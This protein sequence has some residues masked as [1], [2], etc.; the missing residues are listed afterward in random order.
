MS[1][2]MVFVVPIQ[3]SFPQDSVQRSSAAAES[4]VGMWTPF[5]TYPIGTSSAGHF[6]KRV[7]KRCLLTFPCKRLTPFTAPLPRI[8]RYAMLKF[9][10]ESFEFCRPSAS[11]S[12][13]VMP[14]FSL[15]Y[16][17]RYCSMRAGMKR[18][19]PAATA[20]CVVKRFPARVT[21]SATSNG[22][23]VSSIKF[24][25]RS[26]TANAACPSFKWQTS[27]LMPSARSN[28]H[29]PIPS[30]IS[31]FNRNSGPPP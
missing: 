14:S 6:G 30:T 7:S 31:C 1:S 25:A 15:A 17:P 5:V 3:R 8:A 9:S 10:D 21:V 11:K 19:K 18:S 16:Q 12:L 26:R 22:C 27:G 28:R 2:S 23:P 20:V 4:Q 24:L 13:I 29:P